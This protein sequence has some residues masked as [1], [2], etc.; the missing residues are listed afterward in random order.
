MYMAG[1]LRTPPVEEE[2]AK[3]AHS[4]REASQKTENNFM[5]PK[6]KLPFSSN[7][8]TVLIAR[9]KYQKFKLKNDRIF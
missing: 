2:V 8:C 4:C 5:Q 6:K 9:N 7:A 3:A 1:S